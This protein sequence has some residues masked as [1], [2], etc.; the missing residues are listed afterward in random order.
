MLLEG[1]PLSLGS[2]A[3]KCDILS[4]SLWWPHGLVVVCALR[5]V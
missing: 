2:T 1:E 4:L 3:N 5:G